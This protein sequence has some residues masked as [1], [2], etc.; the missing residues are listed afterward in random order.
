MAAYV[1]LNLYLWIWIWLLS[2]HMDVGIA[3]LMRTYLTSFETSWTKSMKVA[4]TNRGKLL[5]SSVGGGNVLLYP[6]NIM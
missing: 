3:V 1:M 6:W 5:L 4:R 2:V